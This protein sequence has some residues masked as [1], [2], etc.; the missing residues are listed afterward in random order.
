MESQHYDNQL[1]PALIFNNGVCLIINYNYNILTFVRK[2]TFLEFSNDTKKIILG[3]LLRK[4]K[5][6]RA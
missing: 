2:I 1:I 5:S 3:V 4:S 6:M